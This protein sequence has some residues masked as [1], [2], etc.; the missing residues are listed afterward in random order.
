MNPPEWL[1]LDES[2]EQHG[3]MTAEI[4]QTL[5]AQ[6]TIT[7]ETQV[8]AEGMDE[9]IL[10]AQ[11]EGLS[12]SQIVH[13]PQINLGPAAAGTGDAYNQTQN[14]YALVKK[15]RPFPWAATVI[16]ALLLVGAGVY[17]F[18]IRSG[19]INV[20]KDTTGF[21]QFEAANTLVTSG[22]DPQYHGNNDIGTDLAKSARDLFTVIRD[23]PKK[24]DEG[25]LSP[26]KSKHS[27]Y[28]LSL[29]NQ[30]QNTIIL[31][32]NLNHYSDLGEKGK[33]FALDACWVTAAMACHA[34][35]NDPEKTTLIVAVR[36]QGEYINVFIGNPVMDEAQLKEN[37]RHSV[38]KTLDADKGLEK[39]IPY[40]SPD[41][42]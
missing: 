32:F 2:G 24:D 26:L 16:I 19:G 10:A 23:R 42:Q 38:R 13:E 36:D 34:S 27:T 5:A 8:W 30:K 1:Y 14:P 40:F 29:K 35:P 6:G 37:P 11:V 9:W 3:P 33:K 25:D 18:I 21:K 17:F 15:Q 28:C 12:F 39:I 31:I 7:P 22:A 4:L 41:N 20:Y